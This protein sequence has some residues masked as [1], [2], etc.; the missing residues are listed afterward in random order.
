[1]IHVLQRISNRGTG[2]SCRCRMEALSG[3]F[4]C[5]SAAGQARLCAGQGLAPA[6]GAGRGDGQERGLRAARQQRDARGFRLARQ[7]DRRKRRR[8]AGL[9]GRAGRGPDR[10][11]AARHCSMRARNEDYERIATEARDAGRAPRRRAVRRRCAEVA[12]PGGA[13]AQ[14]S[15]SRSWRSISSAPTGATPPKE[16]SPAS[17]RDCRR[18][19]RH[20]RPG[21]ATADAGRRCAA[22]QGLGDAR[23]R[24]DRP[25]RLGL[26][27]PPLHRSRRALQVRARHAATCRARAKCASTCSRAS[28]PTRATAAPSRCC[29]SAPACTT[30]RSPPSARSSTTST[31]RTASTAARRR[32]ASASSSPGIAGGQRDDDA[33]AGARRRGARRPLPVA[34]D[35]DRGEGQMTDVPL[36]RA[37]DVPAHGVPFGEAMKVWARVAALSLRR[38]GRPDR[39]HASHHRRGEEVDRRAA[40]PAG[41]ELLHAAAR[42]R[43]AAARHLHRLADAQD[44]GRAARRHAVRAAGPARHHGAELD[45]RAAR[46]GHGGAGPVLRPEGGGA[47][48]RDRG[49]AARRPARARR[50]TPC[51][52]W[53]P[54]PSSPSSSTT[55]RSRSIIVLAGADRLCRRPRRRA[56]L[57][58]RRRPRQ[59]R[60]QAGGRRRVR[61]LARRRPRTPG[62]TCAGRFPS[63]RCSW[64]SGWC[65]SRRSVVRPGQ[66][67][68]L[69]PDRHLLQQDGRRHLRRRL[70]RAGLRRPAGGRQLSLGDG[71]RDAGRARHGRDDA[72]PADH[73]DAVRGLPRRLA[74]SRRPAAAARR[75]P[76]A[77]C[78]PPG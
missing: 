6:A 50:T 58:G 3:C 14:A 15:S 69:H 8:G 1:M 10:R 13:A 30:R 52:H 5:P 38:A 31:S 62:P 36:N 70:C 56:R 57:P 45:L 16:L 23:G 65:R 44:Q 64:R 19:R 41:A 72:R 59:A 78:S 29:C 11:G 28:T 39:G 12:S 26:A 55:C 47:G 25:H 60:R 17:R 35:A 46:Q 2:A 34:A 76:W 63:P 37:A 40:F 32:P 71:G 20:E 43:G 9:R 61:C 75:R 73:G 22:R 67:Q 66:R 74:R 53:R 54:P 33:A 18:G 7:G 42:P 21:T 49:G 24:A 4:C 51:G 27:D 48:D 68:R 77:A